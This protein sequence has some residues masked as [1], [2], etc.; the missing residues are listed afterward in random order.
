MQL[1]STNKC[2][3]SSR[4]IYA[5]V[6]AVALGLSVTIGTSIYGS[7]NP[8]A[9]TQSFCANGM[10]DRLSF[11]FLLPLVVCITCL[12]QAR[13]QQMPAMALITASGFLVTNTLKHRVVTEVA[14]LCGAF[15]LGSLV[16]LYS[17][18]MRRS[19][20]EVLLAGLFVQL[21]SGLAAHGSMVGGV[22]RGDLLLQPTGN[23][24]MQDVAAA[25]SVDSI[26]DLRIPSSMAR[27]AIMVALG[28]RLSSW[29]A[30]IC[31]QRRLNC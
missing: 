20:A 28:L 8:N 4:I 29:L 19:A 14:N 12:S 22:A 6:Q 10:P 17:M 18:I 15:T 2:A 25:T 23:Y 1:M 26:I 13:W 16:N 21:P 27:V 31:R 7:F 3:G 11:L 24:T 5:V 9:T 30:Y